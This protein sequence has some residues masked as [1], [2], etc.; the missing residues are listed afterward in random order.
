MKKM[1]FLYF[2]TF[3]IFLF[4]CNPHVDDNMKEKIRV[5]VFNGEGASAVC[6]I[7]TMEALKIDKEICPVTVSGK[8]IMGGTFA[9]S[10]IFA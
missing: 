5:G 10:R 4:A 2:L 6:V 7:E 3:V 8:D 1:K 9:C